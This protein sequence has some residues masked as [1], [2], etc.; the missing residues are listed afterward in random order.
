MNTTDDQPRAN[1]ALVPTAGAA[2]SAMLSV[3]LARHPVSTLTAAPAVPA[4]KRSLKK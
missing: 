2:L 4:L 1:N 3:S